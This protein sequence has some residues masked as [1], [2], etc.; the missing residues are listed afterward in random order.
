MR[1][2]QSLQEVNRKFRANTAESEATIQALKVILLSLYN[3][4]ECLKYL[5]EVNEVSRKPA[6]LLEMV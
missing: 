2:A 5:K 1:E 4:S 6:F 3:I